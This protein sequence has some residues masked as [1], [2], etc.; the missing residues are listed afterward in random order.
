[1]SKMIDSI[2]K[3][4]FGIILMAFSAILIC[5]GQ[6]FWKLSTSYGLV[7]LFLGFLLYF[8]G[9]LIMLIAYRFGSLSVLQPMLSMNYVLAIVLAVFILKENFSLFKLVGIFVIM[10][11]VFFM[12]GGDD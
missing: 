12:A 7:Y 5:F 8:I 4:K 11:G 10:I 6:L 1:M 3:N 9:A 2:K